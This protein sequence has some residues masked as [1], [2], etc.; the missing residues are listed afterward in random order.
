M[1]TLTL[2]GDLREVRGALTR[3][4]GIGRNPAAV[5]EAAGAS[6]IMNTRRRMERGV[7]PDST[8]WKPLNPSYAAVKEGP[9]ILRG[10][11]Y[12]TSGLY[13]SITRQVQGHTLRWGSNKV[14]AAIHQFGGVIKPKN[15]RAL[16]FHIG[17]HEIVAGSVRIPARPYLG[18]TDEDR[19][20]LIGELEAYLARA[21]RAP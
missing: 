14:Y 20:D 3:I 11:N 17:G 19:A 4:G 16:F 21:M 7:A 13:R 18:F 2:K 15:K 9:G 10:P 6:I 1:P 12:S 8:A 5:L